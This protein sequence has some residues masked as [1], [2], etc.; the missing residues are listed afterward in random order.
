M[1]TAWRKRSMCRKRVLILEDDKITAYLEKEI[2]EGEGFEVEV[3]RDGA[4][5]LERIRQKGY[6]IIISDVVMPKMRGDEFYLAVK[7]L[8]QGLEKRI[9]FVSGTINEFVKSTGNKYLSKPFSSELLVQ[10]VR[11][12]FRNDKEAFPS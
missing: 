9:I 1:K 3:A 7:G 11:D 4:E 5:G 10:V 8:S 6:D 2:L 12:V